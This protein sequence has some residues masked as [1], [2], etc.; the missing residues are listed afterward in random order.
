M[1]HTSLHLPDALLAALDRE[2]RRR[3][4]SRNRLVTELLHAAVGKTSD[5]WSP[6]LFTTLHHST[7]EDR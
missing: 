1:A 7:Y 6:T 5:D 3:G 4:V 2:A